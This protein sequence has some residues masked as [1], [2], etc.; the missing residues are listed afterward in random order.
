MKGIKS[1]W[2]FTYLQS[3]YGD[4]G[5][6]SVVVYPVVESKYV[7]AVYDSLQEEQALSLSP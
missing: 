3:P 6:L 5:C 2:M 4:F 7:H 1:G